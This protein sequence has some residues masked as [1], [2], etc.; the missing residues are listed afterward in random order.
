MSIEIGLHCSHH[1]GRI[2]A[3][4]VDRRSRVFWTVYLIETSLAYNLGRPPSISDAHITVKLPACTEEM[5]FCLHH[6][7]HRRIQSRIINSVYATDTAGSR[8]LEDPIKIINDLQIQLDEWKKQL[9]DLFRESVNCAYPIR[10]PPP[11]F[12]WNT[13]FLHLLTRGP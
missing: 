7:K 3:D 10:Y 12:I 4:Q 1:N 6:L 8:L 11:F 5:R 13:S 2:P 9:H